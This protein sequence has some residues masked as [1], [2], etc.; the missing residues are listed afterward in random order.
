MDVSGD[1]GV[2]GSPSR[3]RRLSAAA[4]RAYQRTALSFR[5]ELREPPGEIPASWFLIDDP[6][7]DRLDP[8]SGS[9]GWFRYDT[10]TPGSHD[11]ALDDGLMTTPLDTSAAATSTPIKIYICPSDPRMDTDSEII[12]ATPSEDS[13]HLLGTPDALAPTDFFLI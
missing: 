7:D 5:E 9:T 3:S 11:E 6:G 10:V 1:T 2:L 13:V 4:P 8:D 12:S